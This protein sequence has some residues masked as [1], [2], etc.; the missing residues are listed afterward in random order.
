ME[1][2]G[3]FIG[4]MPGW[5][6]ENPGEIGLAFSAQYSSPLAFLPSGFLAFRSRLGKHPPRLNSRFNF[7]TRNATLTIDMSGRGT[8]P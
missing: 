5:M 2:C 6:L 7:T 3:G 1:L 8:K 4:C